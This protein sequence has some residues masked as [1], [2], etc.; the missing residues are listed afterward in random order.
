MTGTVVPIR[1]RGDRLQA[2][3]RIRFGKKTTS[4]SG[5]QIPTALQTFR[6]TS[7]DEKALNAIAKK[8][9]GTV[10]PWKDAPRKGEFEVE[11]T[12][13][14]IGVILPPDDSVLEQKYF[15]W[16]KR[17]GWSRRCD[18]EICDTPTDGP[19]FDEQPCL[20]AKEQRMKCGLQ[21]QLTVLLSE[22]R[23]GG[24]W[25]L[26][27]GSEMAG[28]EIPTMISLIQQLQ[29]RG[30]TRAV[31]GLEQRSGRDGK[32]FTVPVLRVDASMDEIAAGEVTYRAIGT[33][34]ANALETDAPAI[35]AAPTDDDQLD[36][37]DVV[38]GE[39]VDAEPVGEWCLADVGMALEWT[40]SKT[41]ARARKVAKELNL[42]PPTDEDDCA[43]EIAAELARQEGLSQ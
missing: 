24:A 25:L 21:T 32:R 22:I 16:E 30:M 28:D 34:Q 42:E 11:T 33:G 14:E 26:T 27:T 41:L 10:R 20:C 23:L 9:G 36:D 38:E 37:D 43:P 8:Y 18:G 4:S 29:S 19:D 40:P 31:L 1:Q 2:H 13:S 17:G 39:I 15:L 3:G 7:S 35:E 6:F 12:A 5:K